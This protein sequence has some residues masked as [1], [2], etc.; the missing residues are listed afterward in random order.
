VDPV[1]YPGELEGAYSVGGELN[2][3]DQ[4]DLHQSV[5]LGASRRPVL[6]AFH[7]RTRTY[8]YTN[9]VRGTGNAVGRV[10]LSVYLSVSTLYLL[11]RLS[12]DFEFPHFY[13]L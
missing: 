10:R 7:L 2:D 8:I 1:A 5:R 3:I 4:A 11:N 9:L 12:F 13:E 6:V